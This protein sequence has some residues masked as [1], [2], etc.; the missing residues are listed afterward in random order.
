[1]PVSSVR[2]CCFVC[3]FG[4]STSRVFDVLFV[5]SGKAQRASMLFLLCFRGKHVNSFRL[6]FRAGKAPTAGVFVV[7][8]VFSRK[9]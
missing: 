5:F 6:C 9:A 8:F 1:M 4:E 7:S 3:V 2:G